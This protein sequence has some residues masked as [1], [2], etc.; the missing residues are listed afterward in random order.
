MYKVS[1][2]IPVYNAEKYLFD[3]L[4]NL[5]LLRNRSDIELIFINDGS[6][7]QSGCI[8]KKMESDCN[9]KIISQNNKGVSFSRNVGIEIA[10]GQWV[11]F[12]DADDGM[13]VSNFLSVTSCLDDNIDLYQFSFQQ[14]NNGI[15]KERYLPDCVYGNI[16]KYPKK[17]SINAL[18]S[19]L[20]K[21][22]II[23]KHNIYLNTAYRYAE[24]MDFTLRYMKYIKKN[25]R[26]VGLVVYS[27]YIRSDSAMSKR[28]TPDIIKQNWE[29]ID[30]LF[31]D[32]IFHKLSKYRC[33]SLIIFTLKSISKEHYN[34]EEF[35][36][37]QYAYRQLY[38]RNIKYLFKT[39]INPILF[40]SIFSIKKTICLYKFIL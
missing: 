4:D 18:W 19:Y 15:V 16:N 32:K 7:D 5:Q 25:I 1:I 39:L 17:Y 11:Y 10:Q 40:L 33:Y 9:V 14:I 2:I 35:R 36:I 23:K 22:E 38:R 21:M 12:M 24:D 20:Y 31:K 8:L 28:M 37:L 13:D 34:R 30:N 3:T 26:T 27:Y 29:V 6:T